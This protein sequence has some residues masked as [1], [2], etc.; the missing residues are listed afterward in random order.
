M[1][2]DF[3]FGYNEEYDVTIHEHPLNLS[4]PAGQKILFIDGQWDLGSPVANKDSLAEPKFSKEN[5]LL[6][7][8]GPGTEQSEGSASWVEIIFHNDKIKLPMDFLFSFLKYY[9]CISCFA[10]TDAYI[11]EHLPEYGKPV[12]IETEEGIVEAYKLVN[13]GSKTALW[14]YMPV[15]AC[16]T[17]DETSVWKKVMPELLSDKI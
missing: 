4:I 9:N 2:N 14:F 17:E 5:S 16:M 13:E 15:Y 10:V 7:I 11:Y 12:D 8:F 3:K 1:E 6:E